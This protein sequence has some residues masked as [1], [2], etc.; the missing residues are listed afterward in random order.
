MLDIGN[1]DLQ[2]Q[3]MQKVEVND[4]ESE[5]KRTKRE[6]GNNGFNDT[7]KGRPIILTWLIFSLSSTFISAIKAK[8]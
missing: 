6:E 5:V 2:K 4:Q 7:V 1:G 8:L 3:Y